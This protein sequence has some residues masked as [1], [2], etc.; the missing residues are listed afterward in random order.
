MSYYAS[1]P[2]STAANLD[3]ETNLKQLETP[4]SSTQSFD[5]PA[6]LDNLRAIIECE[7]P[8]A[9]MYK[10][11]G[12]ITLY[13][14]KEE[15]KSFPLNAPNLLVSGSTL[16]ETDFIYGVTALWARIEKTQNK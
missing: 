11:V 1:L 6:K 13:P 5:T 3:G 15:T 9:D 12:R 10:F 8:H 16:K 4:P 7:Y 2:S 14:K